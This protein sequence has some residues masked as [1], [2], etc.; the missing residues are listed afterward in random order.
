METVHQFLRRWNPAVPK[1]WLLM[2]A[3]VMWFGVSLLLVRYALIWLLEAPGPATLVAGGLGV[4]GALAAY[5]YGFSQIALKNSRRIQALNAKACFFS[6]QE[7]KGYAIIA[8]M[9]TTGILLRHS[10]IPRPYLIVV[11][12]TVG[13]G[14]FLSSFH[15]FRHI[16]QAA[17]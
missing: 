7:W 9:M 5:W 14:L 11:Y 1:A 15:Y 16:Y 8:V 6:F 2:A 12:A 10:A 13:G 17:A 3:G 4:A